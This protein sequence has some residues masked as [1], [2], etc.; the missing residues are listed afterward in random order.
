MNGLNKLSESFH[1]HT[2]NHGTAGNST[3]YVGYLPTQGVRNISIFVPIT[4]GNGNDETIT[5][6]TADDSSGTNAAALA[7]NVPIYKDGARVAT[8]AKAFTETAATGTFL[9]VFEVPASLVPEGKYIGVVQSE[10]G[11]ASSIYSAFAIED[12]YYKG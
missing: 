4:M 5:V 12:T 11:S 2:L 3:T 6:R 7:A 10:T 9:Y 1:I 8:D